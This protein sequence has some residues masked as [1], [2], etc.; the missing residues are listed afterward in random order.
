MEKE[1][2][3]YSVSNIKEKGNFPKHIIRSSVKNGRYSKK[4]MLMKR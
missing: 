3:R 1:T 4:N 2:T